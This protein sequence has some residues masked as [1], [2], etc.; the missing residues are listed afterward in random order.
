MFKGMVTDF[1]FSTLNEDLLETLG[2][3]IQDL[4]IVGVTLLIV[5]VISIL[6]EKGIQVRASLQ[7]RNVVVRWAVLYALILYIIVFGAYGTGYIPVD[8][9]YANF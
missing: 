4:I 6:N 9:I 8:P 1:R 7:K 5:F 2:V 3:D